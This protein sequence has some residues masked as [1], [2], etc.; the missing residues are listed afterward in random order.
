MSKL[1]AQQVAELLGNIAEEED[2]T[3]KE[4]G[5]DSEVIMAMF[6]NIASFHTQLEQHFFHHAVDPLPQ[7]DAKALIQP[8]EA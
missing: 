8:P 2:E 1:K 5:S 6:D 7:F 3:E 4:D